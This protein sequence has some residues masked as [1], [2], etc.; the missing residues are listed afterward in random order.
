LT[1]AVANVLQERVHGST[2]WRGSLVLAFLWPC[3]ESRFGE[4]LGWHE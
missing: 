4:V 3:E 2:S 1:E